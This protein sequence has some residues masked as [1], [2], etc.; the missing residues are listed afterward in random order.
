[1]NQN[2]NQQ[3]GDVNAKI[4]KTK[5]LINPREYILNLIQIENLCSEF[6]GQI[7]EGAKGDELE[8]EF[9]SDAGKKQF[10]QVLTNCFARHNN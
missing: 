7:L 1:M 6:Y 2:D 4:L 3:N 9:E 8:I 10:L 5:I